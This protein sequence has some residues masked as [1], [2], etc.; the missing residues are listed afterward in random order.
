MSF[1][2]IALSSFAVALSGAISPGPLLAVT[3]TRSLSFGA[4]EGPLLITGHSILEF[5][6]VILLATGFGI[7]LRQPD[8]LKL[9]G[10]SAD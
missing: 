8:F 10:L 3:V 5:I 4:R 2:S 7:Y 6:M 1:I 9:S